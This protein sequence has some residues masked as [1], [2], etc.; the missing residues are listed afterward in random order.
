MLAERAAELV[1]PELAARVRAAA[2]RRQAQARTCRIM[3]ASALVLTL[4]VNAILLVL[5]RSA[6][7]GP[8]QERA[9]LAER[10]ELLRSL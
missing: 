9:F 1:R 3:V 7:P 8:E 4:G 6:A 2:R 10:Y 5:E